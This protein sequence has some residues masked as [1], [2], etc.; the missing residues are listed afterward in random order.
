MSEVLEGSR[1]FDKSVG[2]DGG[3]DEENIIWRTVGEDGGD[4]TLQSLRNR[5][6]DGLR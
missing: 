3:D 2:E 4:F 6:V 5:V 1:G